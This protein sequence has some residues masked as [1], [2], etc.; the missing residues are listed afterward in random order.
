MAAAAV[1]TAAELMQE[2]E[3]LQKELAP[4]LFEGDEDKGTTDKGTT[5]KDKAPEDKA[6][7][8]KKPEDKK[9][10]DQGEGDKKDAEPPA[11]P[12][13]DDLQAELAKVRHI[14]EVA[15]GRLRVVAEENRTLKEENESLKQRIASLESIGGDGDEADKDKTKKELLGRLTDKYGEDFVD[16]MDA[17][18]A[19][20]EKRDNG[21][22]A[23]AGHEK[24]TSATPSA[25]SEDVLYVNA[26]SNAVSD[27]A[28]IVN[29]PRFVEFLT[30]PDPFSGETRYNLMKKAHEQK[31]AQR[32]AAFYNA[33]KNSSPAE[34]S[35][36]PPSAKKDRT[37][38][39][40]PSSTP[41]AQGEGTITE[42]YTTEQIKQM[43]DKIFEHK[44][45]N[46]A[47]E[48]EKLQ[49]KLDAYLNSL[50][51]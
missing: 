43:K 46:N 8:D 51:G 27:W 39:L 49:S 34:G 36:E 15:N 4:E 28:T 29:D 5:D 47:K 19:W 48:A 11:Q 1:K 22:K 3:E 9:A 10:T 23:K 16:D 37:S 32:V 31:D 35:K 45:K 12:S 7:E 25:S 2:A 24:P 17:Y 33:F 26:L 13:V 6:P 41:K 42:T 21:G 30:E 44:S 20:K 38:R 40:A 14:G 18:L 50:S